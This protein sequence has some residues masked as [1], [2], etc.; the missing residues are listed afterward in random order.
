MR[1]GVVIGMVLALLGVAGC[2]TGTV[3]TRNLVDQQSAVAPAPTETAVAAQADALRALSRDMLVKATM[4]GAAYGAVAGCGLAVVSDSAKARCLQAA[5]A[6]GAVG[7]VVGNVAGRQQIARRV[8]IVS[9]N[10]LLPSLLETDEQ[11]VRVNGN[12]PR[13][14]AMQDEELARLRAARAQGQVSDAEYQARLSEIRA[15]RAEIARA[16]TDS[17]AHAAETHARLQEAEAQG[18]PGLAWYLNATRRL[19]DDAVSARSRIDLL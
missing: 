5:A 3:P 16:L 19:Q 18:Q 11:L 7:A 8:E 13:I 15:I 14:M 17:A 2:G 12:I 10:R 4:R 1:Q 9:L 6:G